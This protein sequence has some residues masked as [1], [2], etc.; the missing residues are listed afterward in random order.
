MKNHS[1][2]NVEIHHV[3]SSEK[4][5]GVGKRFVRLP[6]TVTVSI[7]SYFHRL[8]VT[9]VFLSYSKNEESKYARCY[10]TIHQFLGRFVIFNINS[11]ENFCVLRHSR[12][13]NNQSKSKKYFSTIISQYFT[14]SSDNRINIIGFN[15]NHGR[16]EAKLLLRCGDI[17]SNPGPS[18][19]IN[20]MNLEVL[21]YNVRG[22]KEYSKLKRVLNSCSN[23]IRKNKNTL[24]CLQE[25]HLERSDENKI[26][27]MWKGNYVM[28]PGGNKSRGCITLFDSS[29]EQIDSQR[30]PGGRFTSLT[31]KKHFGT[32]VLTNLYAPNE[33]SLDFFETIFKL[34]VDAR[35]KFEATPIIAG[36][37]NLVIRPERDSMNRTASA[38]EAIVSCFV[39]DSMNALSLIDS[40]RVINEDAG[41]TW[42][43]GKCFSRLD[44]IYV[45]ESLESGITSSELDW[46]FDKSDHALVKVTIEVKSMFAR[47][48]GLPKVDPTILGKETIKLEVL[49]RLKESIL[50]IPNDWNPAK[51]WEFLKVN[52]R[53]IM[54]EISARE[55]KIDNKEDEAMKE[56]LNKLKSNKERIC[57]TQGVDQAA[58]ANIDEAI[59]FFEGQLHNKW[60]SK[61]KNLAMKA[62]VK[63]FNEGEKSNKYFLNIIK[64]RQ[65][66]TLLTNLNWEG[67]GAATQGEIQ[68]L[69]VDF[70]SEL[71]QER[72]DLNTDYESFFSPDTPK[73]SDEDRERMDEDVT[74]DE[75]TATLKS[76][77]DTAPGPDGITYKTY[78]ALW[79]VLGPFSLNAWKYSNL[80]GN[81]T[82][83]QKNSS[84][85]LLP[86]EGKDITQIGNWRP[87]TLTNCDLKLYT[88]TI[89]NRVSTVLDGL[90]YETQTAYIPGRNVHNNLRMFEF[91]KDYC[92]KND[93][94]AILMSLDAKKAFDSVDH[95]YMAATL[96]KYG[97]SDKF[98][99][100]VKLLYR[101]IK[102]DILVNGY[103]T[104][105]IK[106]GR[107]VKQGDA[108][109][110]ALF[111]LCLDPLIRNIENNS[112]IG[113]VV[114][115]T[116]MSNKK[117]KKKT[118]VFADDVGV[119][120]Q[121]SVESIREVYLEYRRFTERSGIALNE[122]KT[123][124][125]IL[126]S[127]GQ[128]FTPTKFEIDLP[129]L[130]FTLSSV[131]Q[132][133]I[134]GIA[135]S[136]ST[137]MSYEANITSKFEKLKKKLLAWQYRGLSLGGKV[138][139]VK[140]FGI[141]QLIYS[142][143]MCDYDEMI[144]REIESFIFGFLWSRNLA[145]A[146]AP[147]RIKRLIM[148]QDYELG[149][150]KVPDVR[151][152]NSALK[153]KQ[154]F[155][156]SKS[157]HPIKTLQKYHLESLE[158]DYVINQE[159]SRICKSDNVIGIAQNTINVLTDKWR[160][161]L[162]EEGDNELS[163]KKLDIIASIDVMEYLK[164]KRSLLL[165]CF[166]D[167][168]LRAGIENFKQLVM[169]YTF[170]RSDVFRNLT[171]M[172]L[173]EFPK[174]WK[175][176][177]VD[178]IECN[179][180]IDV[181]DNI[182]LGLETYVKTVN[183]TVKEIR[184][185][186][187]KSK[188]E[189]FK[190]QSVLGITPY[191]GIN[192]FVTARLINHSMSQRI[193]KFRLLHL[194]IFT[195]QRMF[196]FKMVDSDKCDTCG[197]V[198]TIKHV[199]WECRRAKLVWDKINEMLLF[200]GSGVR[201]AFDNIFVGFNPTNRV[202]ETVIT[203][204]TQMLLSYERSSEISIQALKVMLLGFAYVNSNKSGKIN[205]NDSSTWKNIS[206]W[207]RN[208]Y[209]E[210]L[211]PL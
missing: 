74:L 1:V 95:R 109:S 35:D 184:S 194:D 72:T 22:L 13:V 180:T 20:L 9:N 85:T 58:V 108:L 193:F 38:N 77:C 183:C 204:T 26:R 114:V 200:I 53:S 131:R 54:W 41:F 165:A 12:H 88:K 46:A 149:G 130:S 71:Y 39:R 11:L 152:L 189:Q 192:P 122:N 202:V 203:R 70:Y 153:L 87:I 132:I 129:N 133:V 177:I 162:E 3:T 159:Y 117:V 18:K 123:E 36:D 188:A 171:S 44:M 91:Y 175:E 31:V 190:F 146:R 199:L 28:S 16:K 68:D 112:R 92:N 82:E 32:Y 83:S 174:V 140:T 137:E 119:V 10:Y 81:L 76:C 111:I 148:K 61:S 210:L 125:L 40:Y 197:E 211:N 69:V 172:I 15:Q 51:S 89:A 73:L 17:E 79:E 27:V 182:M 21:S 166:F 43:R 104:V 66:E 134:C 139:V 144:L 163:G 42:S 208:N 14:N 143:Q 56:Q 94:D 52:V 195:K 121:K 176:S 154:F 198:E 101:D 7:V 93:I 60:E 205:S 33:Q 209:E 115:R 29:W 65:S 169:E 160:T 97:F 45:H 157:R 98:I 30:D 37:F 145:I 63:W 126:K 151:A 118:G 150:L 116:P 80:T 57:R 48:T 207:C 5:W 170:P 181:R 113:A 102:A 84:I 155:K 185:R 201:I 75:I 2:E 25:T 96:K 196:K 8:Y 99:D 168:L 167:R 55:K 86:K 90:I 120:T 59:L 6:R 179:S 173:K 128:I 34:S 186:I 158:Y 4:S 50:T 64:K 19:G 103:R 161:E 141:S 187:V 23:I 127:E 138:Q 147:D 107:C 105:S 62:K 106:I 110:C 156:A 49:N 24:I 78:Q 124:I 100:M 135:F 47:G 164:R 178:N 67:R 142:M 191:D 136:N 206:I